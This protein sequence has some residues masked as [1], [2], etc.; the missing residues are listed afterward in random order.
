LIYDS[1]GGMMNEGSGFNETAAAAGRAFASGA[2]LLN[3]FLK[4]E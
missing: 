2:E 4:G 3:Y 1:A